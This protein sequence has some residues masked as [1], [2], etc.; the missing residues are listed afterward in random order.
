MF[1]QFLHKGL[2]AVKRVTVPQGKGNS[3]GLLNTEAEH[4]LMSERPKCNYSP[5]LKG[6]F[7]EARCY[8][9]VYSKSKGSTDPTSGYFLDS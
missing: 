3:F 4:T 7:M 1:P 9:E 6:G 8:M 5:Y 2:T